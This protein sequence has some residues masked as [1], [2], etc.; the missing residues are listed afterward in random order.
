VSAARSL[1]FGTTSYVLPDELLPNVRL[2][3][4]YIDDVELVLFEGEPGNLPTSRDVAELR[5]LAEAAGVGFSVHLPLDVGLGELET[6]ARRRAQDICLRV[7]DLTLPLEPHAFVVHPEL[8]LTFHPALGE[9]PAPLDSLPASVEGFWQEALGESFE[10]LASLAGPF[11]LAVENL[12]YPYSW[13]WPL[14]QMLD[15]GVVLDVGHLLKS[16]GDVPNHLRDFGTRLTVVHLHGLEEGRDHQPLTAYSAEDLAGLLEMF[17]GAGTLQP[18]ARS[19]AAAAAAPAAPLVVSLEVFGWKA[20]VPSLRHLA[21]VLA[22][23]DQAD[24]LRRGA[25]AVE[26]VVPRYEKGTDGG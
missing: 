5:R 16:G 6:P 25:R 12:Q 4:P 2:L 18:A 7:V 8:P 23:G 26:E 1:L 21:S 9:E 13:V 11:P 20:T 24:R 3:A 22:D 17:A 10:R 19:S 14:V 15:L